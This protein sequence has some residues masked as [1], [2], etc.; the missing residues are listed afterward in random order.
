MSWFDKF[1]EYRL[2]KAQAL[3]N[4]QNPIGALQVIN[5]GPDGEQPWTTDTEAHL[6]VYMV[7]VY[8]Y[9][10]I[11]CI[12]MDVSATPLLVQRK[13]ILDGEIVWTTL[14]EGEL[15][16]LFNTINMSSETWGDL[17]ERWVIGLLSAGDSY[18]IY[19][20]T[21]NEFYY[22]R[23]DWVKVTA[24]AMG[25]ITGYNI[26]NAGIKVPAET[27]DVIHLKLANPSGEYYGFPPSQVIKKSILTSLNVDNY[28]NNFFK[29]NAMTGMVFSTDQKID[30]STRKKISKQLKAAYSGVSNSFKTI[31]AEQGV[32][33]SRLSS[34]LSDLITD[35]IDD[36]IMRKVLAA[37]RV[38]PIKIGVL[39]GASYSN[40]NKQDEVYER[41]AVEP[42]RRKVETALTTQFIHAK[43][44]TEFRVHY[45]RRKITGLQEDAN[46]LSKRIMD[47]WKN[48]ALTFNE[49]RAELGYEPIDED[50]GGNAFFVPQQGIMLNPPSNDD[51][52][53]KRFQPG[54]RKLTKEGEEAQR[55]RH[56]K[57]L[58]KNEK[59]FAKIIASYFNGQV[60]RL[61]ERLNEITSNGKIMSHLQLYIGKQDGSEIPDRLFNLSK[62]DEI[63][64]QQTGI[65]IT[66]SV[67]A[68]GNAAVSDFNLPIDFNAND[69]RV[70]LMSV[71][72]ATKLTEINTYSQ[73]QVRTLLTDSFGRGDSIAEISKNLRD[74][75]GGWTDKKL[76][77]NR[78]MR[79]ARTEM[80]GMVNGGSSE[81]YLQ[82]GLGKE[83]L[84]IIDGQ[85]RIEH[86]RANGQRVKAKEKFMVGGDMLDYPSDPAGSPE[87]IINCRCTMKPV[88][89]G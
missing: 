30:D 38:P 36:Q 21:D 46:E 77:H 58:L 34:P 69:P 43:F 82:A 51:D 84:A 10:A 48:K 2:R 55:E 59:R 81:A 72:F 29:N 60:N 15:F 7:N 67:E 68:G 25:R 52:E 1:K 23:P 62:E 57:R 86:V 39:D 85:T 16:D 28:V 88:D 56:E 70:Q 20:G 74:L 75:Y 4:K 80:N 66:Q 76:D 26:T 17:S 32:T 89:V 6:A 79:I 37:Y 44:G 19:D 8:A 49:M 12:G 13:E 3:I 54:T 65:A 47:Q 31:I 35:Q 63:L 5:S 83:W 42:Y 27:I 18:M 45:D 24:D 33:L 22:A 64:I 11:T 40:A 87:N 73:A 9:A 41:G 53:Q 14:N 61:I 78:S 71:N 50:E